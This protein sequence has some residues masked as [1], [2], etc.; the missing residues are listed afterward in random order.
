EIDVTQPA[1]VLLNP[2]RSEG[3]LGRQPISYE[4]QCE[5]SFW[6]QRAIIYRMGPNEYFY[7][8]N[9][10]Q[11]NIVNPISNNPSMSTNQEHINSNSTNDIFDELIERSR[12]QHLK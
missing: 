7:K 12:H 10:D 1:I 11:D 2:G 9:Y 8:P 3:A 6:Q 5:N 4:D